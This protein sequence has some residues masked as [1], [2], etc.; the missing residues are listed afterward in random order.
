M[1]IRIIKQGGLGL[2]AA[3]LVAKSGTKEKQQLDDI[4]RDFF[5]VVTRLKNEDR[6]EISFKFVGD[7]ALLCTPLCL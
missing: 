4:G 5:A 6:E 1:L 2:E 3:G 7:G